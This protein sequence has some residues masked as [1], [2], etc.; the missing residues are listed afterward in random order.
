MADPGVIANVKLLRRRDAGAG[1][2]ACI[3][4]EFSITSAVVAIDHERLLKGGYRLHGGRNDI[5]ER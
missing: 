1:A 3:F 4:S 5:A 2:N